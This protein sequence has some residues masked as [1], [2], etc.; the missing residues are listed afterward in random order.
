MRRMMKNMMM[1]REEPIMLVNKFSGIPPY[2]PHMW[3]GSDWLYPIVKEL[4]EFVFMINFDE[5]ISTL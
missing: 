3:N 5:Q 2:L 4:V 1:I